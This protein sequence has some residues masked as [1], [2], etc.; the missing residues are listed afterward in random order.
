MKLLNVKNYVEVKD[1]QK[2]IHPCEKFVSR[3]RKEPKRLRTL[4][5]VQNG[6]KIRKKQKVIK[7][8]KK[9]IKNQILS[10]MN[11]K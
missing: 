9:S 8:E 2:N 7:N 3:E 4:Y 1:K 10:K 5:Q 11:I 6:T